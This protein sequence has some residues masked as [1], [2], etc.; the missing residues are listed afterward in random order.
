MAL[1][2]ELGEPG[3]APGFE[4]SIESSKEGAWLPNV[5]RDDPECAGGRGQAI[6]IWFVQE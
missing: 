6:I 1:F 5:V 4:T 3:M 2:A